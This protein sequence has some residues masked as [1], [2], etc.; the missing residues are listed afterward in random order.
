M[1]QDCG[2]PR[3]EEA[4]RDLQR[5]LDGELPH[6]RLE[7]IGSH[8]SACFPCTD[9]ASFEEEFRRVIRRGCDDHAPSDLADR[10]RQRLDRLSAEAPP[11]FS[12]GPRL[13]RSGPDLPGSGSGVTG[14]GDR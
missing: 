2:D 10:I 3:C 7:T 9:R 4:L 6:T 8:L 14:W 13:G 1:S 12:A 11:G 5:Y